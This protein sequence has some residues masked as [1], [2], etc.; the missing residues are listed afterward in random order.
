MPRL[1]SLIPAQFTKECAADG[2]IETCKGT[3]S[4]MLE[5]PNAPAA[6]SILAGAAAGPAAFI[7]VYAGTSL[8]QCKLNSTAKKHADARLRQLQRTL[9]AI[10]THHHDDR[11]AKAIEH[12]LDELFDSD[13]SLRRRFADVEVTT[14]QQASRAAADAIRDVF[15]QLDIEQS[16]DHIRIYLSNI[17][18]WLLEVRHT[19]RAIDRKQDQQLANDQETHRLLQELD[20]KLKAGGGQPPELSDHDRRILAEAR[21]HG[22]AKARAQAAIMQRDFDAADPL[23]EHVT[24]RAASELFDALTLKGDRHYFAGEFDAAIEP[25]EKALELRPD[26][27]N[28]RNNAAIAHNQARL[29]NIAEHQQRAIE[30]YVTP[31]SACP[32]AQPN[33]R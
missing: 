25:Y 4:D 14:D 8:L 18:D 3:I 24:Q 17:S 16:F 22:D 27:F 1:A 20:R 5:A 19:T 7:A 2:F 10:N 9:D 28:A 21:A 33:G 26:D 15:Q 30:I 12:Q 23:I 32:T 11:D 31:W 13:D 6:A 29:G